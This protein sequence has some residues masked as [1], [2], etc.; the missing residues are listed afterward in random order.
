MKYSRFFTL[1]TPLVI[2]I[3]LEAFFLRSDI[4][5][6]SLVLGNLFIAL[7]VKQ[8]SKESAASVAAGGWAS[9]L[10]LPACFFT[11]LAVYSVL[12]ESQL[13]IQLLFFLNAVFIYLYL[14]YIYY[15]LIQPQLYKSY[16]LENIAT[17]GNFLTV[18]FLASSIYGLQSFL[19]IPVWLLAIV[20]TVMM[21]LIIY[22]VIWANK[23]DF[24]RGAAYILINC[25]L[26]TEAAW[27]ISFLPLK[28]NVAGLALA[29][30]YY[31]LI[32]LTKFYLKDELSA[33]RIKFYLIFGLLSTMFV[34]LTARWL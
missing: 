6:L 30:Y 12:L 10:I 31:V 16:F 22:N 21:I 20:L 23:I 25:L 34:L 15:Y 13:V 11:S 3:L 8:F 32:S 26:L 7:T 29:I 28:Y 1:L 33:S 27:A 5:Y 19:G 14:R 24:R 17:Y 2:L 18:F 4:F 9:F